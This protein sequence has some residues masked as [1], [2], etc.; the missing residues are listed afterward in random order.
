PPVRPTWAE[1]DP[2]A[3][4]ANVGALRALVAPAP[5]WA[6]VKADGYGHGAVT[7]A[8]AALGAGAAG[9]A[10]A[11]VEEAEE[12]RAAGLDAPVLLLSEPPPGAEARVVAADLE[13]A[14][15]DGDVADAL[16]AAATAAGRVLP[17]HL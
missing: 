9:L 7:V 15:Y 1:V 16:G 14:V 4:A 17:V 11:L 5:L 10:V 3:V 6:V 12:L 8:R 13:P 2:E